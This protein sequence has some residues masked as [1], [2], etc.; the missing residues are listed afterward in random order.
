MLRELLLYISS[1]WFK[2]IIHIPSL[3]SSCLIHALAARRCSGKSLWISSA[4]ASSFD[5]LAVTEK[6]C[7]LPSMV[8]FKVAV[9]EDR[10][11]CNLKLKCE[12]IKIF[13]CS[14]NNTKMYVESE[15]NFVHEHY[16]DNA[17]NNA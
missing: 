13:E 14:L 11:G 16:V 9:A 1:V 2:A 10:G 17:V 15:C 6:R 5:S 7:T 4:N 8:P 12:N 3:S